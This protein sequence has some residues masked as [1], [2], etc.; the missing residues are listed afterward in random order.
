MAD[1]TLEFVRSLPKAEVH[2]HL[3]GSTG[4][5]EVEALAAEARESLPRP[6]DR[7]FEFVALADFLDYLH[8]ACGLVRTP[9]QL[10]RVAYGFAAREGESGV[11]YADMLVSPIHWT[12]WK[13]RLREFVEAID[14]GLAQAE[15]DGLPPV[16]LCISLSRTFSAAEAE[17]M[18][19]EVL[20]ARNPR[21]V[22]LAIDGNEAAVGRTSPR[23]RDAFRKAREAGLHRCAHAGESSGPEGVRDAVEILEV[24]RIEH[25]VRAIEDA[26]VVRM[27]AE[28][29]I[30]LG[31]CPWSNVTLGLYPTREAHPLDALRRAGVPASVNTDDPALFG[32]RLD[33]EYVET[34]RAY[35]WD[36]EIVRSVARTSIEASF[37]DDDTRRTL[38]AELDAAEPA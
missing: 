32:V 38:L 22:A 3:E 10:A 31:I 33:E 20:R 26:D 23:F 17:E 21:V 35:G 11:R 4:A 24:E 7:L 14:S 29:R 34:A 1:V 25:G 12:A 15:K 18:T 9:D 2:V 6:K 13:G 8:W 16:G 5:D 37:C 27:L 19:D 36:R 28:R 30:P